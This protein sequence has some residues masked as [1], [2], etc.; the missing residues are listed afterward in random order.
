MTHTLHLEWSGARIQAVCR[1]LDTYRDP[2]G[3]IQR[4][5]ASD[6]LAAW[7]SKGSIGDWIPEDATVAL[8]LHWPDSRITAVCITL[9]HTLANAD[10]E[11]NQARDGKG[12]RSYEDVV[13]DHGQIHAALRDICH[14]V[15]GTSPEALADILRPQLPDMGSAQ[16]IREKLA[17]L[18][19][20]R[21]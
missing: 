18:L 11:A 12:D 1:T 9:A 16:E 15:A 19:G 2:Q 21:S 6:E 10:A 14:A 5:C 8:D 4:R 3:L 13:H 7:G 20:D 17:A